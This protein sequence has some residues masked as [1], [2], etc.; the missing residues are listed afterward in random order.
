MLPPQTEKYRK[1]Y[2]RSN[3]SRQIFVIFGQNH[4]INFLHVLLHVCA[5][6]L[7]FGLF[8][9]DRILIYLP[10]LQFCHIWLEDELLLFYVFQSY[11]NFPS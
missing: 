11:F 4:F 1:I 9:I 7:S 10:C 5:L 2:F 8:I 3:V 6:H